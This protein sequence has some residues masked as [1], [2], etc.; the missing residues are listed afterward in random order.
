TIPFR[1]YLNNRIDL[2][3]SGVHSQNWN[4]Y[5]RQLMRSMV[6]TIRPGGQSAQSS[7]LLN[8]RVS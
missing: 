2:P 1:H 6:R 7:Q 5:D 3:R 8:I 4:I